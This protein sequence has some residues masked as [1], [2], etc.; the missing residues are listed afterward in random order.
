ML[1]HSLFF[2]PVKFF[3]K[4]PGWVR[5]RLLWGTLWVGLVSGLSACGGGGSG[6][7]GPAGAAGPTGQD[8]LVNVSAE[9]A[10]ANCAVAGTRIDAGLDR[11]RNGSL[12]NNEIT[13]TQYACGGSA[14]SNGVPTLVSMLNESAGSNC[15]NG[16]KKVSVG[17]DLNGNGALDSN[18]VSSSN[19]VCNGANG[20]TGATGATGAVGTNGLNTLVKMNNESAGSNCA[21]GGFL[22]QSGLDSDRNGTL[23]AAEVTSN[24]YVCNGSPSGLSWTTLSS[25]VQASANSGYIA[26]HPSTEVAITLP[27]NLNFG[28]VIRVKGA[29]TGTAGWKILQNAGQS[30]YVKNLPGDS[31]TMLPRGPN[32]YWAAVASSANGQHLLAAPNFGRLYVSHD[33]GQTWQTT[34]PNLQWSAVAMSG[35]GKYM[36]TAP[37]N[38]TLFK[39]SDSGATWD[40]HSGSRLYWLAVAMSADGQK[41]AASDFDTRSVYLWTDAGDSSGGTAVFTSKYPFFMAMAYGAQSLI[42]ADQAADDIYRLNFS[43]RQFASL[44]A[45]ARY[46][47]SLSCNDNC[48]D[49]AAAVNTDENPLYLSSGAAWYERGQGLGIKYVSSSKDGQSLLA[50]P[51]SGPLYYTR[52]RGASWQKLGASQ[53]WNAVAISSDGTRFLAGGTNSALY[54]N[55]AWTIPGT[56]GSLSGDAYSQLELQYMGNGK[57][58]AVTGQGNFSPR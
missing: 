12:D 8:A 58:N 47:S 27:T 17:L 21:Y 9:A 35:D 22:V 34:G 53:N 19:Y 30:I 43:T 29:G 28:D 15:A 13:S 23:D 46:W 1:R 42:V 16:G 31:V 20:N 54:V 39:S 48:N 44:G 36:L 56:D 5:S 51:S 45:G 24:F 3:L 41:W 55:S 32:T 10:G 38:S 33:S 2:S 40:P 6:S 14:G 25:N 26:N 57:F 50:A 4:A 7:P 52:N 49:I 18:E 11:D 37:R